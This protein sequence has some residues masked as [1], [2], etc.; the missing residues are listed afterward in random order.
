ME[1]GG[2]SWTGIKHDPIIAR[3]SFERNGFLPAL[4]W[5][6]TATSATVH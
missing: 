4:K 1:Q 3:I 6:F 5:K 2:D